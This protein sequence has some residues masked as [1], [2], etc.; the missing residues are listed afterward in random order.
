LARHTGQKESPKRW[1]AK[2]AWGSHE[3]VG[4][5]RL[6]LRGSTDSIRESAA[7]VCHS[8]ARASGLMQR[9]NLGLADRR[10]TSVT[11]TPHSPQLKLPRSGR[12]A[13]PSVMR[14][15]CIDLP[16]FGQTGRTVTWSP[17]GRVNV[18]TANMPQHLYHISTR[19]FQTDDRNSNVCFNRRLVGNKEFLCFSTALSSPSSAQSMTSHLGGV[20][21]CGA[22][23][24]DGRR[25]P[26]APNF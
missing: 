26:H 19:R 16:Q 14:A 21:E 25:V 13:V 24:V 5:F 10:S 6:E 18:S 20:G 23:W 2:C 17:T 7:V 15:R 22:R 9:G 8:P 11:E 3:A 12:P 4:T 1:G